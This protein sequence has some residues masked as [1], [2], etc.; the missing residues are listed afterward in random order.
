MY[1]AQTGL[2][3]GYHDHDVVDGGRA[4]II[5]GLLVTPAEVME[6]QPALDLLWRACFRWQLRPRQVTGDTTYATGAI[7]RAVEDAGMRAA[8]SGHPAT[9]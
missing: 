7:I 5:L 8:P 1:R 3:V 4:R 6:N 9:G 2:R